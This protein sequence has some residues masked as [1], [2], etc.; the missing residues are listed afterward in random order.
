MRPCWILPPG[1][2]AVRALGDKTEHLSAVLSSQESDQQ[3]GEPLPV[4]GTQSIPHPSHNHGMQHSWG[5]NQQRGHPYPTAPEGKICMEAC[6]SGLPRGSCSHPNPSLCS[7][8]F[9]NEM[10]KQTG[11]VPWLISIPVLALEP[12]RQQKGSC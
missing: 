11:F 9:L 1:F 8:P 4:C 3:K 12:V 2:H 6:S 10:A 5:R 7:S